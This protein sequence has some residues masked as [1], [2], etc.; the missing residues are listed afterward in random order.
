MTTEKELM[1]DKLAGKA[2]VVDFLTPIKKQA[3]L[4]EQL[5]DVHNGKL[6]VSKEEKAV[7]AQYKEELNTRVNELKLMLYDTSF[8]EE[9][10]NQIAPIPNLKF[11]TDRFEFKLYIVKKD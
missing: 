10:S 6:N 11:F 2:E 9:L 3:L 1:L 5:Q 7:L 4:I 8:Y